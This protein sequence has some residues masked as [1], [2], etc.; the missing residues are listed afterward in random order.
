M[1]PLTSDVPCTATTHHSQ[2]SAA[3]CVGITPMTF[4][5]WIARGHVGPGPW[6]CKELH[7]VAVAS[8]A[9]GHRTARHGT[10]SRYRGGCTCASCRQAHVDDSRQRLAR[11]RSAYWDTR[12][13]RLLAAFAAGMPFSEALAFAGVTSQGL[14]KRRLEDPRFAGAVDAAL[15]CG[16]SESVEH[17]TWRGW[18]DGCRCPDCRRSHRGE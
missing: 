2:R 17:G 9:R 1:F 11:T 12:G 18:R 14:A 6:K 7:D 5:F 13:P 16:R 10:A 3:R 15:M 4:A 8:G